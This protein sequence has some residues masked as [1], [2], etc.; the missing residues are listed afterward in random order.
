MAL[1]QPGRPGTPFAF[2]GPVYLAAALPLA[3][4]ALP[5]GFPATRGPRPARTPFDMSF[6]LRPPAPTMQNYCL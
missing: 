3:P 5:L 4:F 2:S 6:S 1:P